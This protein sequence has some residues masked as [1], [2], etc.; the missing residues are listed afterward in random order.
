M[1]YAVTKQKPSVTFLKRQ[2]TK[3]LL[4][5]TLVST[6]TSLQKY[7]P[8]SVQSHQGK[9]LKQPTSTK[10]FKKTSVSFKAK[11]VTEDVNL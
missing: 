9:L 3:V 1:L 11:Q 4:S 5:N 2:F 6:I 7:L 8:K 10:P